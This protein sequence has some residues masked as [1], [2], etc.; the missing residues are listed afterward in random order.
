MAITDLVYIDA[1]GYHYSDYPSF[2][3]WLQGQYQAIYGADVYLGADSQDGQFVAV[4]KRQFFDSA[5]VGASVYNS[6]SPVT[7][8][9]VGLSRN[10]KINGIQRNVSSNSTVQLVLV[11]VYGTVLTNAIAVD[12]LQQQWAIPSPTTIPSSG[13]V[14]V[15]ATAVV[16][17]ALNALPNTITGIFTPTQGW[18]T[19]NNPAAATPGAGVESDV[20]LRA[21]QIVSTANPSQ[22]VF[23]GT[24]GAVANVSGVISSQGYENDTETTD[25]N[26]LPAHSISIVVVGGDENAIA[27]AIQVH[28]TPGTTTYGTTTVDTVDS[29]GMPVPI[30]FYYATPATIGV[31]VTITPLTGYDSSYAALIQTAISNFINT[32]ALPIGSDIIITKLYPLAYLNGAPQSLTYNVV[33]IEIKK[34]SGSYGTTN[35]Q[36]LF[37][38]NPICATTNVSVVT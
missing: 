31:Q 13:T 3:S 20:A 38:E 22:T 14:T 33:S 35:I 2:L 6:F 29:R 12:S 15:T 8:Q 21:R 30:N 11:G 1:T 9:G 32:P 34:N 17:G 18:Q 24:L 4:Y 27:D 16:T 23:D 25:G 5:A 19:V 36:L 7:A 37:N 10:V 28:K 26:G